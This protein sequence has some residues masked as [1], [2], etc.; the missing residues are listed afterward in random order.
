MATRA[1]SKRGLDSLASSLAGVAVKHRRLDLA[2]ASDA[3]LVD[4][5]AGIAATGPDA[6][7]L[8][9]SQESDEGGDIVWHE[10]MHLSQL[11]P[12]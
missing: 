4:D 8:L 10:S 1:G 12:P 5:M 7:L 9:A 3:P 2:R 6:G 11:A